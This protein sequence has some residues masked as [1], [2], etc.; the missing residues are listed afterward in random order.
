MDCARMVAARRRSAAA[1]SSVAAVP[2]DVCAQR[3][4]SC[5]ATEAACAAR[6]VAPGL[7]S[8]LA[9]SMP[10]LLLPVYSARP[11]E[12]AIDVDSC[13]RRV[14]RTRSGWAPR[15]TQSWRSA[16]SSACIAKP[17]EETTCSAASSCA[18]S[19][20]LAT[21]MAFAFTARACRLLRAKQPFAVREELCR[22]SA[23]ARR[24]RRR[25]LFLWRRSRCGTET[26]QGWRWGRCREGNGGC[27]RRA[28]DG[29][30]RTARTT[31]VGHS[32]QQARAA[33]TVRSHAL[34]RRTRRHARR[35]R[36][37]ARRASASAPHPANLASKLIRSR[38]LEAVKEPRC[39]ALLAAMPES[40][41]PAAAL[42]ARC[43]ARGAT[44]E[45]CYLLGNADVRRRRR[46]HRGEAPTYY[47]S[48]SL[49]CAFHRRGAHSPRELVTFHLSLAAS[50][51]AACSS[52]CVCSYS[53]CGSLRYV[54]NSANCL[55]MIA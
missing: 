19:P 34:H 13:C 40:A 42:E 24:A 46:S 48:S 14:R 44:D 18:I 32:W 43:C 6:S 29:R 37:P 41:S 45:R 28:E 16:T 38:A 26:G 33:A 27:R 25:E 55:F 8:T 15:R 11:R 36:R 52:A 31:E 54:A 35:G 39:N 5:A 7:R 20:A 9:P 10:S 53:P 22:R 23:S 51:R 49:S 47:L 1:A 3:A 4:A 2:S 30:V 21:S 50:A 12:L 17:S